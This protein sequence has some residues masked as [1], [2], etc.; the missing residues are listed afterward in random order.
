MGW[1]KSLDTRKSITFWFAN[2]KLPDDA[3]PDDAIYYQPEIAF[4]EPVKVRMTARTYLTPIKLTSAK[5][6]A[7][8]YGK[9][10]AARKKV[11][12]E[13]CS[14]SERVSGPL[15]WRTM[16]EQSSCCARWFGRLRQQR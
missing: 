6:I 4:S 1:R 3:S 13:R 5:Q 7:T 9:A 12:R 8:S 14:M 15:Y 10:L 11:G 2:E 16:Q